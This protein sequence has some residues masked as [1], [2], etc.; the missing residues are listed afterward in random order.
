[1]RVEIVELQ[2]ENARQ[3]MEIRRLTQ[4][5]DD[6]SVGLDAQGM[7]GTC[8]HTSASVAKPRLPRSI[9]ID[10]STLSS[11]MNSPTKRQSPQNGLNLKDDYS[12]VSDSSPD[13]NEISDDSST[14]QLRSASR[15]RPLSTTRGY[16]SVGLPMKSG[17]VNSPSS[18]KSGRVGRTPTNSRR[19][20]TSADADRLSTTPKPPSTR[21]RA[22]RRTKPSS[23]LNKSLP[24]GPP[25]RSSSTITRSPST[26]CLTTRSRESSS[27]SIGRSKAGSRDRGWR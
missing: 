12:Q 21:L 9:R 5:L 7:G 18:L 23:E 8:T 25:P 1:M 17:T 6:P 20:T 3:K 16:R 15:N 24:P 2:A 13:W 4:R 11:P 19:R 10:N 26:G 27:E 22:P 14:Y